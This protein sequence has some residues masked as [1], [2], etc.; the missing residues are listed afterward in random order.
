VLRGVQQNKYEVQPLR[1]SLLRQT[2]TILLNPYEFTNGIAMEERMAL[3][4][5]KVQARS[6]CKGRK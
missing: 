6:W 3:T 1:V 2:K 4:R 5:G